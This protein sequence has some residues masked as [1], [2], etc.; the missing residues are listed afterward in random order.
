MPSIG[1]LIYYSAV[2]AWSAAIYQFL[3]KDILTVSIGLGRVIQS[4]DEFP[5]SCQRIEHPQLEACE[6]LWLD[7]QERVLY[8]ACA[9][10]KSRMAWSPVISRLDASGRRPS[11]SEIIA[12]D[13]DSIA[14]NGFFSHRTIVPRGSFGAR[15][16][17]V[18]DT[19]GFTSEVIDDST[20]H[21]YFPNVAPYHG[22]YFEAKELGANA[23]VEVFEFKRGN[24][25][26]KHLRTIQSPAVWSPNRPAAVGGGAFLVSN[27]HGVKVGWRKQLEPI[28]G[29][30]TVAYCS[31]TG[32]CHSATLP[33]GIDIRKNLKFPNGLAKGKDGLIYVPSS[34]DGT[35]KVFTLQPNQTLTQLHTIRVGMPLD[36]VSPDARGD[37]WVSGF[38]DVRQTMKAMADPYQ[39]VS[40]ATVFRIRKVKGGR[41]DSKLEYEVKKMIE[42]KEGAIISGATTV[43]HDVKSGRLFL[44]AAASPFIVVCE[45]R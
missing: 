26:M 41:E 28:I 11:G 38:P 35:V 16:D 40:P 9:G 21:F 14:P 20:I 12:L 17:A 36:N 18:L 30:G 25:E 1:N 23:T 2:V 13:I 31:Y 5:Y 42:D 6:D 22:T 37:L 3:I 34:A 19:V 10:T 45:P 8:A 15:G 32:K 27:D 44:G 33:P 24:D 4:I 29:G 7:Q 43:V 39:H